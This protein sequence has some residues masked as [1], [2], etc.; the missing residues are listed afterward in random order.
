MEKTLK[1]IINQTEMT[2]LSY[3]ILDTIWSYFEKNIILE[4]IEIKTKDDQKQGR[5]TQLQQRMH[6]CEMLKRRLEEDFPE[7]V[8][9]VSRSQY[10]LDGS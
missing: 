1:T 6:F 2:S 7:K 10:Q 5:L 8:Y 9:M 4:K 3:C